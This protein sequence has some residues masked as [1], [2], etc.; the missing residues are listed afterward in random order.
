LTSAATTF[1][2][3][4]ITPFVP[5]IESEVPFTVFGDTFLPITALEGTA[6]AKTWWVK[7][8]TSFDLFSGFERFATVP[9][10]S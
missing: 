3:L 4:I 1:A 5:S 7:I 9:S 10:G 6:P 2:P 8:A